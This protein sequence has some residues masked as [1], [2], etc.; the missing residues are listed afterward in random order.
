MI[1]SVLGHKRIYAS[2]L[3]ECGFKRTMV[4]VEKVR[5]KVTWSCKGNSQVGFAWE[6]SVSVKRILKPN[7]DPVME[8]V[9]EYY[10]RLPI[11]EGATSSDF[12]WRGGSKL[13]KRHLY[14]TTLGCAGF[15]E[16][17]CT[18]SKSDKQTAEAAIRKRLMPQMPIPD[19][20]VLAEFVGLSDIIDEVID[21][22]EPWYLFPSGQIS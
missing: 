4:R 22:M 10:S 8:W 20:D 11:R 19:A 6:R 13:P 5:T 15:Q 21:L 12:K 3:E 14:A 7:G 16:A 2:L 9:P 1:G 17:C 18:A